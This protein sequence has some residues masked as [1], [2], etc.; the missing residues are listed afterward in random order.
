MDSQT[1]NVLHLT[2]QMDIL[3][4]ALLVNET[5]FVG[6]CLIVSGFLRTIEKTS[7]L[8]FSSITRFA[9]AYHIGRRNDQF[10]VYESVLIFLL[11]LDCMLMQVLCFNCIACLK[12]INPNNLL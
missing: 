12:K 9:S 6:F 2:Q 1:V 7:E 10:F 8:H 11:Y 5:S 3:K 4:R